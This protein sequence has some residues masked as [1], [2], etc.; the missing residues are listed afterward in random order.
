M[1]NTRSI[2]RIC[3]KINITDIKKITILNS[4]QNTVY[5]I[6]TNNEIYCLKKYN[7]DSIKSIKEYK[8]RIEQLNI[9]KKYKDNNINVILP[10]KINNNYYFKYRF[11]YY[12]LYKYQYSSL[13][14]RDITIDNIKVM[15]NTLSRIHKLNIKTSIPCTYRIIKIDFNK[16]LKRFEYLDN[17]LYMLLVDNIDKLEI[18]I[19]NCNS[20]LDIVKKDLCVNHNDYKLLNMLWDKC[21]NM[22]LIDFDASG[23]SNPIASLAESSFSLSRINEELNYDFYKEFLNSYINEYGNFNTNFKDALFVAVNGKLQWLEYLM[24]K[25]NKNN[26]N[27]I[28]DTKHMIKEMLLYYDNIDKMFSIYK[29]IMNK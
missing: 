22:Y 15:A 14:S 5:K 4:S 9:A 16:Y 25:C 6:D 21:N 10:E 24:S 23:L 8:K 11:N 27:R 19:S 3:K 2:E 12:L 28:N 1:I 18:L 17:E 29:D 7:K 20:Y 13:T 26:L